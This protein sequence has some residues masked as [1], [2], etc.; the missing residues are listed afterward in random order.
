MQIEYHISNTKSLW[1]SHEDTE[2]TWTTG[3]EVCLRDPSRLAEQGMMATEA[4]Y[5]V[6]TFL[7]QHWLAVPGKNPNGHGIL[8]KETFILAFLTWFTQLLINP[9][10][11]TSMSSY[12]KQPY[13]SHFQIIRSK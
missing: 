7:D 9:S 3:E 12:P 5:S 13:S 11:L 4:S 2:V 6:L 1:N 10:F 8:Q